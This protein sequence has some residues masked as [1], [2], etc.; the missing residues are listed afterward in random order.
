MALKT[1]SSSWTVSYLFQAIDASTV[2]IFRIVF[3][4]IMVWETL[5]YAVYDRIE[6]YY[7]DPPVH[8][9]YP[10][11]GFVK[12]LPG[13][14]MFLPFVVMGVTSFLI[15]LGL[16][17][18]P[19]TIIFFLTYTY[20][21]LID[22][23]QY[24][25]HYYF[26]C[27]LG[28]ILCTIKAN[29][30]FSVDGKLK[31]EIHTNRVPYWQLYILQFQIVV[32][33]FY[34]GIA[35]LN[36]DWLQG[37]PLRHWLEPEMFFLIEGWL[38]HEMWVYFLSYGG[39][40]FDL[41]IGFGLL[42]SKTRVISV[43]LVLIFN[44]SNAFIFSIGVFPFLMIGTT[45]LFL[46]PEKVRAWLQKWD[47]IK[48]R[49]NKKIKADLLVNPSLPVCLFLGVYCAVQLLLPFRHW[50]YP[51]N[52]SWNEEGHRF[53][54]HMK[55]RSK[56]GDISYVVE[57]PVSGKEWRPDLEDDLTPRQIKKMAGRPDMILQY[58]HLLRDRYIGEGVA[59]PIVRAETFLSY[60]FRD[61]RPFIDPE[62]NLS[63][64]EYSPWL[65][66]NWILPFGKD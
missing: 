20:I 54:W 23:T 14:W 46:N 8:F 35:K 42:Y 18:L 28:L 10:L 56:R 6:G 65:S 16:F 29:A 5:R 60:N 27:L 1:H 12:A 37:E 49:K 2:A 50:L 26:I 51:G 57:D 58:A 17:Y 21:F 44:L 53:A 63:K 4:I 41:L 36:P 22:S 45:V 19:A 52:V 47:F 32:V 11:F 64:L 31:P 13:D 43:L 33:Y 7:I 59:N 15:A 66:N 24:N 55:L 40:F 25:N 62:A 3:G 48:G 30:C 38:T 34:G 39:L 9:T 61:P